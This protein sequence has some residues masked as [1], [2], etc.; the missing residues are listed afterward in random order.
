MV[1][2]VSRIAGFGILVGLLSASPAHA[3]TQVMVQVGPSAP[4]AQ[5]VAFGPASRGYVWQPG[6]HAWTRFG[7]RWVPGQWVRSRYD[8]DGWRSRR[9]DRDGRYFERNRRDW[10]RERYRSDRG[11][12]GDRNRRDRDDRG[13]SDRDRGNGRR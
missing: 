2:T 10:D 9:W 6:Y 11:G 5:S 3:R 1:Q 13:F 7:Y 12:Y 8:R 4:V